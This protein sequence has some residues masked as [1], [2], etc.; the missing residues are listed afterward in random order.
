MATVKLPQAL[1]FQAFD[2]LHDDAAAW[3]WIVEALAREQGEADPAAV[4]QETEGTVLVARLGRER[5]LKLYPP[6][7]RDHFEFE[8]AMLE[9]LHGRLSVPTPG[10]LASGERDGWPFLV[11]TQLRGGQRLSDLWPA[12]DEAARLALLGS[13]GRLTSEVH[14]LPVG[15]TAAVALR[16]DEFIARQRE[17]C[18]TRQQRTRLPP[19]LLEALPR[20]LQAGPVPAG[21]PV[22]LSGE[23]TPMNLFATR[24]GRL[25]AMFDFGDGLVGPR[26][27]DW[28]GPLCFL[29][30]GN[31]ARCRAFM[32]GCGVTM[33]ATLRPQLLRLL[34]LHR[35]SNLPVQLASCTG[36]QE[37][38]D[39]DEL[40]AR[41]WPLD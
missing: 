13:L 26:E 25:T 16:W 6:F 2:A 19:R 21:A 24:Q 34:L 12:M 36:W 5:V 4:Q 23:Y 7:L 32:H 1:D 20:F 41:L 15:D 31:A 22:L 33:T 35:Y 10:L 17:G 11:M 27:Y 18:H 40:A 37:A 9:R 39:L 30:A 3:R 38:A 28:L 29:A 8:R 14:A